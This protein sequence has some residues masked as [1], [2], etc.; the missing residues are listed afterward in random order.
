MPLSAR[1]RFAT[2]LAMISACVSAGLLAGEAAAQVRMTRIVADTGQVT[3]QNFGVSSVDIASWQMCS[4][5]STYRSVG[6]LSP[7][8]STDLAPG[9]SVEITYGLFAS[10]GDEVAL[11]VSG[12]FTGGSGIANIRDYMQFKSTTGN[13]EGIAVSAGLWGVDGPYVYTGDGT[14]NGVA[15]WEM[16]A[17]PAVPVVPASGLALLAVALLGFARRK[18]ATPSPSTARA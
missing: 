17:P 15:F 2:R 4:G 11:Y 13:R 7:S 1:P 12:P 18:L 6:T 5:S 3:I 8:G 14:Q 16:E 9:E 10:T